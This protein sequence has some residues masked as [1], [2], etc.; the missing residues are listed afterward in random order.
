[1]DE[2]VIKITW[3]GPFSAN[4]VIKKMDD[5]GY[6]SDNYSGDDYGVYQIYGTHILCGKNTLLYVGKAAY[7]T[8]SRRIKQHE[9]EWLSKETGVKVYLGRLTEDPEYSSADNWFRWINDVGLVES[10]LIYKYAPNYNSSSIA[11]PP[12][13]HPYAK[14]RLLHTGNRNKL[15][16]IDK[17]PGDYKF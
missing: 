13:L 17:A 4:A 14:V 8:F 9:K 16:E 1:M 15:R 10:I 6:P 11:T 2:H 3:E 7:Q 12:E 5:R